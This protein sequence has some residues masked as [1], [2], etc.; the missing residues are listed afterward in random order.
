MK[1]NRPS[2]QIEGATCVSLVLVKS[3]FCLPTYLPPFLPVFPHYLPARL[4]LVSPSALWIFINIAILSA[5]I[6]ICYIK[7]TKRKVG[8]SKLVSQLVRKRT[9]Y[10]GVF[11]MIR[12]A[13]EERVPL[14]IRLGKA[15]PCGSI[16][17]L[18]DAPCVF[19]PVGRACGAR[20]GFCSGSAPIH[21][22]GRFVVPR[23]CEIVLRTFCLV[24]SSLSSLRACLTGCFSSSVLWCSRCG[25]SYTSLCFDLCVFCFVVCCSSTIGSATQNTDTVRAALVRDGQQGSLLHSA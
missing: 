5:S 25:R 6:N 20:A 10:P 19:A 12:G 13:F 8:G 24:F 14:S 9:G 22:S 4:H 11:F 7:Q 23:P 1:V 2:R 3:S 16:K 17:R 18:M 15:V 21:V